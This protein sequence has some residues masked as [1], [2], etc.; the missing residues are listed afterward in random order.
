MK[1]NI[2]AVLAALSI[3]ASACKCTI[4]GANQVSETERCCNAQGMWQMPGIW[5]RTGK[6][7]NGDCQANSI[8]DSMSDFG[9]CC[10]A[11]SGQRSDCKNGKRMVERYVFAPE[12]SMMASNYLLVNFRPRKRWVS[13]FQA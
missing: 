9:K 5:F 1:L 10:R 6:Y 3:S 4:G 8:K 13:R 11:K 7:V 2:L 12:S